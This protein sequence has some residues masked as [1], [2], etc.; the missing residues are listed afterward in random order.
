MNT[1]WDRTKD[2]PIQA[3]SVGGYPIDKKVRAAA[4]EDDDV[5]FLEIRF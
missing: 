2:L 3:K 4:L 5:Q 1:L